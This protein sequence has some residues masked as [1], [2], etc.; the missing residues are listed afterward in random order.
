MNITYQ[1]NSLITVLTLF[2]ASYYPLMFA[3]TESGNFDLQNIADG[4]YLHQGQHVNFEHH[5]SDDIANIGFIIG[6]ECIAVID[7]GG[8]IATGKKL[9]LAIRE[10]SQLPICYVINTHVH[11]DHVL[12]NL[13]FLN[14]MTQF[15]GHASLLNAI[16]QNR[17][18]FLRQFATNLGTSPSTASIIGPDVLVDDVMKL[19]LG[20]RIIHLVAHQPAHSYSDLTVLDVGTRTLWA[21]DLIFRERIPVLDGKLKGWLAVLENMQHKQVA[22]LIPGHGTISS[23]WPQAYDGQQRYLQMLLSD[24]RQAITQGVFLEDA[25]NSIGTLAK[26]QWLLHEQHHRSNVVKAFTELEWD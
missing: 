15:V 23:E 6:D 11:F 4:V 12:G 20:N 18:F 25:I 26:Q 17:N 21:G 16:E 8:S 13:A 5:Q 1:Y 3:S 14:D 10:I 7:T 22:L 2:I 24:T 19:D 9:R